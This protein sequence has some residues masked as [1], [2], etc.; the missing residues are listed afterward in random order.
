[1]ALFE[2]AKREKARARI[3]LAGPSG[4]GKTYGALEIAFGLG[5]KVAIIDTEAGSAHLYADM[6]EYDVGKIVP[7]YTAEKF[8]Q[9]LREAERSYDVVIFDGISALWSG[10]G[11]LLDQQQ[12]ITDAMPSKNSYTA[13]KTITPKWAGFLEAILASPAHV[14]C[15]ARS[16]ED[17]QQVDD[18]GK[19]KVVKLGMAPQLRESTAYEFTVV[20]DITHEKHLA[21]ASKDRTRLFQSDI[22]FI[23][24]RETGTSLLNWLN[25]GADTPPQALPAPTPCPA[26]QSPEIG[27]SEHANSVDSEASPAPP[28]PQKPTKPIISWGKM[29]VARKETSK[30]IGREITDEDL[31]AFG[32]K[33]F[34][35]E[36]KTDWNE[37]EKEMCLKWLRRMYES[38]KWDGIV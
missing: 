3:L 5:G 33:A 32:L 15:T 23:I 4:S 9:A 16:K 11:G 1:M 19:K 12:K 29:A 22:P 7:P 14:I 36:S 17:Y 20:L 21:V 38:K 10:E 34:K 8:M 18:N 37:E 24:S 6:G 2:K 13:W 30:V 28:E 25:S 26:P 35:K 27:A 31:T